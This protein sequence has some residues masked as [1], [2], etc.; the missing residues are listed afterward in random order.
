LDSQRQFI[1][2]LHKSSVLPF[3]DIDGDIIVPK[4]VRPTIDYD[5]TRLGNR[6]GA[7][8]QFRYK[9]LHIREYSGH[10]TVHVDKVDPRKDPLGHLL[11]DAPEFLMGII[12]AISVGRLV[13]SVINQQMNG[14]GQQRIPFSQ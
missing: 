8:R 12:S 14:R 5:E 4:D 11:I 6:K 3:I 13:H 7:K 2:F 9:N 1:Y 10:Y